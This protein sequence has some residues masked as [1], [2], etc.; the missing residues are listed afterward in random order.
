M[1][2]KKRRIVLYALAWAI[3][4]WI[5]LDA[6]FDRSRIAYEAGDR[7]AWAWTGFLPFIAPL[8]WIQSAIIVIPT[9]LIIELV[10]WLIRKT[11]F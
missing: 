11:G 6:E 1:L 5:F 9:S 8:F 7:S 2:T 4:G 3:L 10:L